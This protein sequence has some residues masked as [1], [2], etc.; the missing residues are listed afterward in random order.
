MLVNWL[1]PW[2]TTRIFPS[3]LTSIIVA[4]FPI[5]SGAADIALLM[6]SSLRKG[7]LQEPEHNQTEIH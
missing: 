5:V 7:P 3:E 1:L 4:P 2:R 6:S